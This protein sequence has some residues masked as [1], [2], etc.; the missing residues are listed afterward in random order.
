MTDPNY[1]HLIVVV[2]R[3]G[4]MHSCREATQ[5][6]VDGF[7]A[8]QAAEPGN[9][10]AS[11]YQFDNEHDTVFEHVPLAQAPRYTL[12]PRGGTALLDAI[13]FAVSREGEWLASLPE[14]RRPGTVVLLIATDGH[15]NSSTEWALPQIKELITR[16]QEVYSW[17]PMFVGANIDAVGVGAS[18]GVAPANAMSYA[19][20]PSGTAKT[21]KAM[22]ANV[23][24]GRFGGAYGFTD[25]ERKQAAEQE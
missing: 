5:E 9:A 4:S 3:S 18:L 6:G 25:A 10:T 2:D 23:S 24:R 7:F 1:R 14:D 11:L 15:E 17:V 21:F 12:M 20:S 16:Q 22:S 13:G 19:P 8:S